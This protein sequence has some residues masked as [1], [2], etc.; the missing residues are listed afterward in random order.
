MGP[1]VHQ[2][3]IVDEPLINGASATVHEQHITASLSVCRTCLAGRVIVGH[4]LANTRITFSS[5]LFLTGVSP[6][7]QALP[8][9]SNGY[10]SSH[11]YLYLSL[12]S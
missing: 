1:V 6:A 7:A 8:S 12:P 2:K 10:H 11:A 4:V 3:S 5:P 9:C